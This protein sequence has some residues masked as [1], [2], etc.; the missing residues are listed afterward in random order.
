MRGSDIYGPPYYSSM[1][2]CFKRRSGVGVKR[3][4]KQAYQVPGMTHP[5]P[6]SYTATRTVS[7][8]WIRR[9]APV[10]IEVRLFSSLNLAVD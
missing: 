8:R 6:V 9:G 1:H 10:L 5:P 4:Q 7:G 3:G 2:S